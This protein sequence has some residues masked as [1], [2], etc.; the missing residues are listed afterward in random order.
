MVRFYLK[1]SNKMILFESRTT[2]ITK[3]VKVFFF[4]AFFF[5]KVLKKHKLS[6]Q[7][8]FYIDQTLICGLFD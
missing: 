2:C 3:A 8:L 1:K 6:F 5:I 7:G 4:C